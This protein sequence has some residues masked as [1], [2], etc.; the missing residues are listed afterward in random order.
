[1]NKIVHPWFK[2][3]SRAEKIAWSVV[4]ASL[5]LLLLAY[6]IASI[7]LLRFGFVILL[8]SASVAITLRVK[9]DK[10]KI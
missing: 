9:V 4:I 10:D 2:P 5:A 7:E 6:G 8:L 3:L 1:M